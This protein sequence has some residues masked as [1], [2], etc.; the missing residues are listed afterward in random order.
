MSSSCSSSCT[1]WAVVRMRPPALPYRPC[2]PARDQQM[3]ALGRAPGIGKS[4]IRPER[5][6]RIRPPARYQICS[7]CSR[8]HFVSVHAALQL[9]ARLVSSGEHHGT[10]KGESSIE[11]KPVLWHL[12]IEHHSATLVTPTV[13]EPPQPH[14]VLTPA[15]EGGSEMTKVNK[16]VGQGV[17]ERQAFS[18]CDASE[19]PRQ[20]QI[21][22][23]INHGRL[24]S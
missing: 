12:C 13:S 19:D 21:P 8:E 11:R 9:R 10:R 5:S 22:R 2:P 1:A 24:Y 14:Y 17:H 20:V 4:C 23:R 6:C 3:T 16:D 7:S 18:S 15:E